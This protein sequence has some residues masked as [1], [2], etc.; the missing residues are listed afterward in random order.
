MMAR[1]IKFTHPIQ[2]GGAAVMGMGGMTPSEA[3]TSREQ[4]L[5]RFEGEGLIIENTTH[6]EGVIP[7]SDSFHV[8]DRWVIEPLGGNSE[9]VQLSASFD[10]HFTKRTLFRS[11][12]E[13]NIKKA[14]IAWWRR[15][16]ETLA[17]VVSHSIASLARQ[18]V[19]AKPSRSH[20]SEGFQEQASEAVSCVKPTTEPSSTRMYLCIIVGILLL[21]LGATSFQAIQLFAL[22]QELHA[23]KQLILRTDGAMECQNLDSANT[24]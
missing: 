18:Q 13:K 7:A 23:L 3:R 24:Y 5:W 12:I 20:S 1:S 11:I 14:T 17:A 2:V 10:V 9:F 19:E 8:L 6:V 4:R 22:T 21:L 15:Y 16:S